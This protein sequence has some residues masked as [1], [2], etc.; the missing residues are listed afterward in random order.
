MRKKRSVR[1]QMLRLKAS[2]ARTDADRA[3]AAARAAKVEA[4]KARKAYKHAKKIAK[5]ARQNLKTLVRK[6]KKLSPQKL[7]D[8]G[9]SKPDSAA[10]ARQRAAAPLA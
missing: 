5:E 3:I 7:R 4:K 9:K 2:E 10:V 8:G 1:V 6:L